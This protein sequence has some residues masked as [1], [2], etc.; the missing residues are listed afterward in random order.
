MKIQG[1]S[2]VEEVFG[3]QWRRQGAAISNYKN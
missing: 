2:A 3:L 1:P